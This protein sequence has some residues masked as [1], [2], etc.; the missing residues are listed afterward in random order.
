MCFVYIYIYSI[1]Y[2]CWVE[3]GFRIYFN[4][5]FC[6]IVFV[7]QFQQVLFINYKMVFIKV[8]LNGVLMNIQIQKMKKNYRFIYVNIQLFFFVE[9]YMYVY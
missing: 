2:N 3:F 6:F 4:K 8:Y 1:W 7:I 5:N 9:D